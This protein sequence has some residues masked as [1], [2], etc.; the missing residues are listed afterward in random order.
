MVKV[1][2]AK[3]LIVEDEIA[4]QELYAK[5]LRDEHI[6]VES[7]SNGQEGLEKVKTFMPDLVILDLLMPEMSGFDVLDKIKSD[8]ATKHIKVIVLT[9]IMP[10]RD[11]LLK[12]G[13]DGL[14]LKF[15]NTPG[16]LI[17]KVKSV[18]SGATETKH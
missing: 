12:S 14:L 15:E 10:S 1:D 8:P 6:E 18:L 16:Q 13:A 2:M 3:V 9:N 4:L 17:E 5:I 11:E 7:A